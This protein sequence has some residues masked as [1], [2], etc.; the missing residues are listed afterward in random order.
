M[1]FLSYVADSLGSRS[2]IA[3][4]PPPSPVRSACLSSEAAQRPE[5]RTWLGPEPRKT[6]LAG[7]SERGDDSCAAISESRALRLQLL[8]IERHGQTLSSHFVNNR[9][10]RQQTWK[11]TLVGFRDGGN[12]IGTKY[13]GWLKEGG[14]GVVISHLCSSPRRTVAFSSA[15]QKKKKNA[16]KPP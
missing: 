11:F 6:H 5:T 10:G 8:Q 16:V 2:F 12:E 14:G 15:T 13:P 1:L 7:Q 9:G 4:P 3:P